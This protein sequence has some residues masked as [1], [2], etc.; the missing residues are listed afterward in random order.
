MKNSSL[1]KSDNKELITVEIVGAVMGQKQLTLNHNSPAVNS[2][3]EFTTQTNKWILQLNQV[4]LHISLDSN[5][6]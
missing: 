6:W 5:N 2:N 1:L 3:D 4:A